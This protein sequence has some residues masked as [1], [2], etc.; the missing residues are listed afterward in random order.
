MPTNFD[1]QTDEEE[2]WQ[3]IVTIKP[4]PK[5]PRRYWRTILVIVFALAVAG[6]AVYR[7]VNLRVAATTAA[8]RQD[9]LSSYNLVRYAVA[10]Q[11]EELF[12]S[13]LS[14]RD[15]DWTEIQHGLFAEGIV[16]DRAPFGLR[17]HLEESLDIT[18]A[19]TGGPEIA[20]NLSPTLE[21]AEIV[22]DESY[23]V[24]A[25]DGI[26]DTVTLKQ[27]SVYRRGSQRW[28]LSPPA[29]TFW[30]EW[31]LI[32]QDALTLIYPERD[33]AIAERLVID[34]D[35]QLKAMCR[36]LTDINC[37]GRR[38]VVLRL[39]NDLASLA[40]TTTPAPV[41]ID[42]GDFYLELPAPTLVGLPLDEAG[43]QA[44][45]RG[46]AIQLVS[47]L[48]T[49]EVEWS[50]CQHALFYQALLDYQLSQLGLRPWP[51]TRDTY[52][53][54]LRDN[55]NINDAALLWSATDPALSESDV[56]QVYTTID[57]LLQALPQNTAAAMQR[58]LRPRQSF[59]RWL[60]LFVGDPATGNGVPLMN[61]LNDEWWFYAYTQ[62]LATQ[63]APVTSRP[64]QDIHLVCTQA[65]PV[66]E[67]T[68]YRY[69]FT[70][71]DWLEEYTR[72]GF[73][74]MNPLPGDDAL[75]LQVVNFDEEQWQ[76]HIWRGSDS[77]MV[78]L[79]GDTFRLS[80]GQTD[81][82]G[83]YLVVYT[84]VLDGTSPLP[85]LVDLD[86]CDQEDCQLQPLLGVPVWSPAGSQ[87]I[88]TE[89]NVFAEGPLL[90]ANDRMSF[91]APDVPL[92]QWR[93]FRGDSE[94][95]PLRAGDNLM[96]IG[97]GY[98]PFWLD[99]ATYG[100]IRLTARASD[101][102]AQEIVIASV[103]DDRP[104]LLLGL[105]EL[106]SAFRTEP[107]P[108]ELTIRYVAAAPEEPSLLFIV[109]FATVE[110][111]AYLFSFDRASRELAL[112]LQVGYRSNHSFGFSPDGRWLVLTGSESDVLGPGSTSEVV[113]LY[114]RA[115]DQTE[116]YLV[117]SSVLL[118]TNMYDWS[119]DSRWLALLV[120]EKVLN[121]VEPEQNYQQLIRH[122]LGPCSSLAWSNP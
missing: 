81:P 120:D 110:R 58:Q 88:L 28:L 46:Y 109:A 122:D 84:D 67:M 103:E 121:L 16:I 113:Y 106:R 102:P 8:M 107:E 39:E 83:R 64:P 43:Y 92:S 35:Q 1:W 30:G 100:Y 108:S 118:P 94:G 85:A 62:T 4:A 27:T 7:Q 41:S 95:Q 77:D 82:T 97:R 20:V 78:V 89:R 96:E 47:A 19:R 87:T 99:E 32:E 51:V 12:A 104:R 101:P 91:F 70:S 71:T 31:D 36:T 90:A 54:V 119:A 98:A 6:A 55:V 105:T 3:E 33:R 23:V 44:L 52:S 61:I 2:R 15:L 56:W 38:R 48:I 26:S 29:A 76:T 65:E 111:Q 22:A 73:G 115:R 9:V 37:P 14:G 114:D 68:L 10:H 63:A 117:K 69:R 112:H 25:H 75:A 53:R 49:Y 42:G 17:A 40:T 45:S 24:M 34:L 18:E 11:D 74:F 80:F 50:C 93:L 66:E 60:N 86:R 116:R 57:F 59:L 13:L 5:P 79:G 21:E 72:P